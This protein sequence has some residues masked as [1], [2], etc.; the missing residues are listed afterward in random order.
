MLI[1]D[2]WSAF[3]QPLCYKDDNS[4]NLFN[5]S[6]LLMLLFSFNLVLEYFYVRIL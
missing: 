4:A 1:F 3:D 5:S 6:S 2:A